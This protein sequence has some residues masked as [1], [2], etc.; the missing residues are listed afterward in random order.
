MNKPP[1]D[2]LIFSKLRHSYQM[3]PKLTFLLSLM[4]LFL[5]SGSVYG[6]DFQDGLDANKRQDYKTAHRLFLPLAEQGNANAQFNLALMYAEGKG[7]QE[8]AVKQ[9]TEDGYWIH[10]KRFQFHERANKFSEE[11]QKKGFQVTQYYGFNESHPLMVLVGPHS[12]KDEAIKIVNQIRSLDIGE[13]DDKKTMKP[14]VSGKVDS[15]FGKIDNE[16]LINFVFKIQSENLD[17]SKTI[18]EKIAFQKKVKNLMDERGLIYRLSGID[19]EAGLWAY[20]FL[21]NMFDYCENQMYVRRHWGGETWLTK[22][23]LTETPV[24]ESAGNADSPYLIK[25]EKLGGGFFT[26]EK[27]R[28]EFFPLGVGKGSPK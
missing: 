25:S 26:G 4:F 24:G 16:N 2:I 5:F 1:P 23:G 11:V 18:E 10:L 12:S 28:S 20:Y 15:E 22:Y 14:K 3:K 9:E 19:I 6:D 8:T 13:I 27:C 21:F 7:V 17:S